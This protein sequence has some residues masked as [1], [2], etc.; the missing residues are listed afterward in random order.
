MQLNDIVDIS[1]GNTLLD[2]V[3][4][5]TGVTDI[6]YA[7]TAKSWPGLVTQL[8]YEIIYSI[9]FTYVFIFFSVIIIIILIG[10]L[11]L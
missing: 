8:S 10:L 2:I 5:A 7:D 4:F 3:T 9:N 11:M 1:H 6:P